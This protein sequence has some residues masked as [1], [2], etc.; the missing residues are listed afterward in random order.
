MISNRL[1]FEKQFDDRLYQAMV[2]HSGSWEEAVFFAR[3]FFAYATKEL[4]GFK[5]HQEEQAAQ[6]QDEPEAREVE[7]EVEV[8]E[9]VAE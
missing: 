5:K 7:A 4:E 6:S 8:L 9:A 1:C 2:P 3:E